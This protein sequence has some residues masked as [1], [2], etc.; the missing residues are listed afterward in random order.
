MY[1]LASLFVHPDEISRT[2]PSVGHGNKMAD[3]HHVL[4]FLVIMTFSSFPFW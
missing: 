4:Q 1:S 2:L 3:E